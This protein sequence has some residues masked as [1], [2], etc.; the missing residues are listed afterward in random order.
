MK[1]FII[2]VLPILLVMATGAGSTAAQSNG[3]YLHY[4]FGTA[5]ING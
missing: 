2:V 1:T 3:P 5:L 4:I